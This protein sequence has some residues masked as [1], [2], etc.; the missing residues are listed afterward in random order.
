M[1][2]VE[3]YIKSSWGELAMHYIAPPS[4]VTLIKYFLFTTYGKDYTVPLIITVI[5]N[6]LAS[7]IVLYVSENGE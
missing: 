6:S 2:R 7:A 5:L 1:Q 3:E 4:N